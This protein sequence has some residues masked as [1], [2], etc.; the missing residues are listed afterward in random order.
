ME[1]EHLLTIIAA[2]FALLGIV[3]TPVGLIWWQH[4]RSFVQTAE[5]TEGTVIELVKEGKTYRPIVEYADHMG[6]RQELRSR[7]G[8]NPPSYSVGDKV[9]IL[10]DRND[11]DSVKINHWLTLYIFPFLCLFTAFDFIAMAIILFVVARF[12]V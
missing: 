12:L 8:T 5:K 3:I 10:Y 4:V 2:C 11:P 6:Q 1:T 7:T 9:Q